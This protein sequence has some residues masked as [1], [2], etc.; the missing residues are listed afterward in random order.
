MQAIGEAFQG[1]GWGMYPILTVSIF[2]VGIAAERLFYLYFRAA[3]VD[4]KKLVATLKARIQEGKVAD[5]VKLL[6]GNP[7]PMS[8]ILLAGLSKWNRSDEE[9][10]SAMDEASLKE[11]PQI[12]KRVGYLAVLANAATLVGL[13]GTIT[14]LI[15][16]FAGVAGVD[17]SMKATL[18]AAGISEAMNCTAF[19]L[20]VAIPSL[21]FFAVCNSKA[22]AIT[23]D[24]HEVTVE[25]VNLVV[26]H[27]R[28]MKPAA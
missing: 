1:G 5:A 7:A 14:G 2:V 12:E 9:V 6:S 23:D 4:K 18:L 26:N 19:G 25:V 15:K 13:L 11:L 20:M 3:A 16:S 28:A 8:R 22:Q 21:L 17:P 10:Q 24:I 27:R